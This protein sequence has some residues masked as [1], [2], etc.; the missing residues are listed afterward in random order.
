MWTSQINKLFK[1]L[2]FRQAYPSEPQLNKT[3]TTGTEDL[4]LDIHLFVANGFVCSRIN[5]KHDDFYFNM[6]NFILI[7]V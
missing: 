2:R 7:I 6:V 1:L 3:N 4:F 5:D